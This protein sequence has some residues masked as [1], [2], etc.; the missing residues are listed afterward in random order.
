MRS[1]RSDAGYD[2]PA[3]AD[4]SLD[5]GARLGPYE[6]LSLIGSGG[7]GEVYSAR[8][9]ELNRLVAI[10]VLPE[11]LASDPV[12]LS[13]FERE[14]RLASALNHPNI[15]TIYNIGRAGQRPYI[16]MELVAGQTLH[17]MLAAGP[18][19]L[20]RVLDLAAQIAG[21]LAK[22]HDAGIVHRDLK[23]QNV[24]V[25]ADGLVK[26]LDFGLSTLAPLIQE[27]DTV[28]QAVP[29]T[30]AG[31]ILGTV[32]YMSPE[33]ASG[34]PVDFRSDQFSFGSL[35]YEMITGRR[36]FSRPTAVQTLSAII[37]AEPEPMGTATA[38]V[39]E[40]LQAIVARCLAKDPE[41]RYASTH[42]LAHVVQMMRDH[43]SQS[44]SISGAPVSKAA[45]R[46]T[47]T[48]LAWVLAALVLAAAAAVTPAIRARF[49]VWRAPR[50]T[51]AQQIAVLPFANIGND[52]ANQAFSDGLV[53][54]LTSQLTHL[55][56]LNGALE[57]VPASDVRREGITSAR[58]ARRVFGVSRAITGSIQR[59]PTRARVTVNLVDTETLRQLKASSID[60]EVQDAVAMQ[61]GVVREV[62]GW[63][64]APLPPEARRAFGVG[65]TAVPSAYEFYLQARGHLQRY[66][67]LDSV[68]LAI[69][70][71]QRALEQDPTYAL[72]HAG[73]GEAYWR[74]YQLTK[75]ATLV[76]AARSSCATA[77]RLADGLAPVYVTLGLIDA[78]TG[79]Y[80]DAVS[81]LK[82]AIAIDPVN[83]D[84]YRE[85]ASAYQAA[86][87]T[88]DAE[89]T[90]K[91]AIQI[92]P[93]YW[94]NY[95]ELGAFYYRLSRYTD[96]E[97]QFQRAIDLTPDNARAYS[98]LGGVYYATKR[99]EAAATMFEKSVAIK[100]NYAA[101]S[102]LGTLYFS[103]G[104]YAE[105]ARMLERAVAINDHDSQVWS[106]MAS[107]YYWAPGEREKARPAYERA[108]GLAEQESRVNPR[109]AALL[110]RMADCQSMLGHAAQ[111]RVLVDRALGLA[112]QDVTIQ[113]KAGAVYEQLGDRRHA[114]EW[115][116]KALAQGYPRDVVERSPS[117][118]ALRADPRFKVR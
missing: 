110:M 65:S 104:R 30:G 20:R 44:R 76:A 36:A 9:T 58:D 47:R 5:I 97:P 70:V 10:K 23:P 8:D 21:G 60:L 31:V 98:S 18:L 84:A 15:I 41:E 64:G 108:L 109:S 32:H 116:G 101:Y 117:L 87:R 50:A 45:W 51:G 11:T 105:A 85:L 69:G 17:E 40:W 100:P 89:A 81:D 46:R 82:R 80:D 16:A 118:A 107:A 12:P 91:T 6:L 63:L 73:L 4:V 106:N 102:N 71:F 112:P 55:A 115:I 103:L 25:N 1:T 43:Q 56:Q 35:L 13:R 93:N 2:S 26:I 66:E 27:G 39:P 22:A 33:Q 86:G 90:F 7:M 111:A 19:P 78:G 49:A 113:Y 28:E 42:D 75:D 67:K 74:K 114:L 79:R 88:S 54:I 68:E 14:A 72:A 94:A 53:E 38:D 92:R 48:R 61:D 24:M 37:D 57:V 3:P 59:T 29:L 62:A 77:L 95:Y 34:R 52:P 99:Y 96:A 83:G